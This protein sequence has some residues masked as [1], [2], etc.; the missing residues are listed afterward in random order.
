MSRQLVRDAL[1]VLGDGQTAPFAGD[2]LL[3]GD[4]VARLG[5]VSRSEALG[6]EVIEARG[7]AL[8]PSFVDTHNHGALG[9]TALGEHGLPRACELALRG[10]V[11][12]RICG[13]DGLSPAPVTEAQRSQYAAQLKPLDGAVDGPWTWSSVAEFLAWHR[14]RSVTDLG[15]HLG[16]S[17]VRRVVMHNL[18]RVATDAEIA[19]MAEV[20]RREAPATLGLSTGLVYNPAVYCDQREL[21]A[22]VRAFNEV[23]PG[24]LFPHLRSESDNVVASLK[25]VVAAAVDGG[26]GYCNEHS[27]IAGADNYAKIGELEAVLRDAASLVPTME[28]MYPYTAGSTTGDAI[29]PPEA[30]AGSRGE[31]LA[32]LRDP[33][34]R[35]ALADKMRHDSRSWDNFIHFCGGL[36]GIQLAGVKPGVGDAFLGKRLADV[37]R[38]AGAADPASDAAYE[39]VFDFFVANEGEV[40][41]ISH[42]GNEATV[43]RFFRRPTMALCTDGLM[44]GPGQKPHPR[45]LGAFPRALRMGRE[46]GIP[47]EQLVWRLATLPC[48]FLHLP[49]PALREG[50][51]ASLVLFDPATVGERNDYLDPLVPPAGID[52]V[53]VHGHR[54]LD[55][56][57]FTVPRPF[58]GRVLASPVRA[59]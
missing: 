56:G 4:R 15:L 27:K 28:N 45:A 14:G 9:G 54:V 44:P 32:R 3:D 6:A 1:L 51:D 11:T 25:E 26:G 39:A 36:G 13:V 21:T 29:F 5:S 8:A 38:A 49:D 40:A 22:L 19:A 59:G 43:E 52:A 35:R 50:A 42:Y 41:I 55:H 16:H 57:T 12:K 2:A 48:R 20:V 34:A 17:A 10:G 23:K 31:F 33:G 30:R 47:L 58:P 37:A 24:A 18:A 7:R 46:L 53:W